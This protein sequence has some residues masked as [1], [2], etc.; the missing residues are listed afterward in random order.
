MLESKCWED[1]RVV[2]SAFSGTKNRYKRA[3]EQ[4]NSRNKERAGLTPELVTDFYRSFWEKKRMDAGL[5]EGLHVGECDRSEEELKE[6]NKVERGVIVLPREIKGEMGLVLLNKMF[7]E[8]QNESLK[9]ESDVRDG[10]DKT[11]CVDVEMDLKSREVMSSPKGVSESLLSED[12]MGMRLST[13]IVAS[14]VSKELTGCY[15]DEWNGQG[16][17]GVHQRTR[18]FG[19][20]IEGVV[21][22]SVYF[23]P[24]GKLM[25][26]RLVEDSGQEY[27]M[28]IRTEGWKA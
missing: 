10:F 16:K 11:G 18:L 21:P 2:I 17:P 8:M 15:F 12:R 13:Y 28:G 25:L 22:I 4:E 27:S 1:S 26:N 6:L 7:P 5:W 3:I 23:L 24:S 9:E 20:L 14:Q 19:S